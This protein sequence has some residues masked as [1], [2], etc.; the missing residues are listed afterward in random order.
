MGWG[1]TKHHRGDPQPPPAL[2][3][4]PTPQ[5]SVAGFRTGQC[6]GVA[7]LIQTGQSNPNLS[8]FCLLVCDFLGS[9]D[10]QAGAQITKG[11][12]RWKRVK[13]RMRSQRRTGKRRGSR[14]A[15]CNGLETNVKGSRKPTQER[16]K[17]AES[18]ADP[19]GNDRQGL[20]SPQKRVRIQ[21]RWSP[22]GACHPSHTSPGHRAS[23]LELRVTHSSAASAP[24]GVQIGAHFFQRWT[25]GS[26]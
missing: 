15:G 4:P 26:I 10:Y 5:G 13:G 19:C 24:G 3:P 18:Q 1:G 21:V 9:C 11:Q 25:R 20:E 22:H 14:K 16:R 17:G 12:V 23:A 2:L 8:P 6:V 7:V